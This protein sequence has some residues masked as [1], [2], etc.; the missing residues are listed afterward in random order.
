MG[1]IGECSLA[2]VLI[3]AVCTRNDLV[4]SNIVMK[5]LPVAVISVCLTELKYQAHFSILQVAQDGS[6]DS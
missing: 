5:E 4:T 3:W 2:V 1:R 6:L